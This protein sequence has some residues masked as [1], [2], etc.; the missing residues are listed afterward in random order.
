MSLTRILATLAFVLTLAPAFAQDSRCQQHHGGGQSGWFGC[1]S[2]S[3]DQRFVVGG[4]QQPSNNGIALGAPS[5]IFRNAPSTVHA[6][7]GRSIPANCEIIEKTDWQ[8]I[9]KGAGEAV[10]KGIGFGFLGA[11]ADRIGR[12]GGTW[13]NVGLSGGAGIGFLQ[14][15]ADQYTMVCHQQQSGS[16][17]Q[18][19]P[20][21]GSHSQGAVTR[22]TCNPRVNG[23]TFVL[24]VGPRV[25]CPTL[26]SAMKLA[27][28]SGQQAQPIQGGVSIAGQGF[29]TPDSPQLFQGVINLMAKASGGAQP[30]AQQPQQDTSAVFTPDSEGVPASISQTCRIGADGGVYRFNLV[31]GRKITPSECDEYK[32]KQRPLPAKDKMAIG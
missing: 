28:L 32:H 26:E 5:V 23:E 17:Q 8:R 16:F 11:A 12:T 22:F 29:E 13:T 14:G 21:G 24:Q 30:A 15:S 2:Y 20:A 9:A 6:Q 18:G 1:G 19:L 27:A 25:F 31:N 10:I 3:Q 7:H 4:N